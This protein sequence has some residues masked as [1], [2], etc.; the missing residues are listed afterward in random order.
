MNSWHSGCTL[1]AMGRARG[2]EPKTP[3]VRKSPRVL[4]V[5]KGIFLHEG[6]WTQLGSRD[7]TP[8]SRLFKVLG[9]T[10]ALAEVSPKET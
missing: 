6:L 10:A 4:G 2:P 7:R 1:K 5:M 3:G 8:G 9:A